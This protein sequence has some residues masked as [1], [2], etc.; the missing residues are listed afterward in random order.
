MVEK[1]DMPITP[2]ARIN[3]MSPDDF[4]MRHLNV[5]ADIPT[6]EPKAVVTNSTIPVIPRTQGGNPWLTK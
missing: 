5:L 6:E 2:T 4:A 3:N 1:R